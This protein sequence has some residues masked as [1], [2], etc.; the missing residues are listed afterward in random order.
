MSPH[1]PPYRTEPMTGTEDK[2]VYYT[3]SLRIK[4]ICATY[5]MTV[6]MRKELGDSRDRKPW[7][8][9]LEFGR[10]MNWDEGTG[11][12]LCRMIFRLLYSSAVFFPAE[13]AD[14]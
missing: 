6:V 8:R 2:G 10:D 12:Y 1:Q 4:V 13:F 3:T 7:P 9:L 5:A 11:L 14:R